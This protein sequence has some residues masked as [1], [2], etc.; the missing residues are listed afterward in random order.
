[1]QTEKV[2]AQPQRGH[3]SLGG[4]LR[5]ILFFI[6]VIVLGLLLFFTLK[7]EQKCRRLQE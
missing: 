1:M 6:P 3:V 7:M 5:N 4:P 2:Y